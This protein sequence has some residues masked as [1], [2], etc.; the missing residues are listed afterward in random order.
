LNSVTRLAF[1]DKVIVQDYVYTSRELAGG[2]SF[3]HLL[4][5]DPLMV[6]ERAEAI[7]SLKWVIILV[8]LRSDR[9][10]REKRG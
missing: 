2:S 1:V 7:F 5:T 9:R 10:G 4:D 6:S 3:R 8:R